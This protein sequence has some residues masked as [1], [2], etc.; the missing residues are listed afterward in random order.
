[1]IQI[2]VNSSLYDPLLKTSQRNDFWWKENAMINTEIW[3]FWDGS[4]AIATW[5]KDSKIWDWKLAEPNC[6]WDKDQ[7]KN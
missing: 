2:T 6:I 3:M 5:I 4:K 7:G 1:M